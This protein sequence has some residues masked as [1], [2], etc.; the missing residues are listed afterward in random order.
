MPT[1]RFFAARFFALLLLLLPLFAS[2][3][4]TAAEWFLEGNRYQDHRDYH[5]ALVA[6]DQAIYLSPNFS[7]AYNN[8]GAVKA[9]LG[10]F[11]SAIE[12]FDRSIELGHPIPAYPYYNRGCVKEKLGRCTE[13]IRDYWDALEK[14]PGFNPKKQE[15]QDGLIRLLEKCRA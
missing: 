11:N 3:Q 4:K 14:N 9:E 8:R 5:N 10:D 7:G 6:F 12:D 2:A 15:I 1:T 13:A